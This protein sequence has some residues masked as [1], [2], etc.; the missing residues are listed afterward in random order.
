MPSEPIRDFFAERKNRIFLQDAFSGYL[1]KM[2]LSLREPRVPTFL[3]TFTLVR[4]SHDCFLQLG[5]FRACSVLAGQ[6]N[7]GPLKLFRA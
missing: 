5:Y 1:E 6:Q 4:T 7:R 3:S 2:F